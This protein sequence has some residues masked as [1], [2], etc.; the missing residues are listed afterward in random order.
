[1]PFD[2]NEALAKLS[3]NER[4]IA[5]QRIGLIHATQRQQGME[6]RNDSIL[7]YK[8]AAGELPD[9]VPSSIATEL[10]IVNTICQQT[11]YCNI[12]EHVMRHIAAVLKN[13][14]QLNWT[15]AWIVARFYV[16]S[17]LKL[18]CFRKIE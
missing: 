10:V 13:K 4:A 7:T 5:H 1:M 14:H 11:N 3:D 16:P 2:I 18:Y 6:P 8:Y 15:D 17:M 9:D 12:L